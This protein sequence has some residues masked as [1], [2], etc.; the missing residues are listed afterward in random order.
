M[1]PDLTNQTFGAY[2]L[3]ALL[4]RG[5]MAAVYRGYQESIDRTVAV[6]VL[7]AMFMLDETFLSRFITEAK[8]LS[9]LTLDGI[10]PLYEF[11]EKNGTPY[12]VMPLMSGGSLENRLTNGPLPLTEVIRIVT[13]LAEALDYAHEQGIYHRDVKPSNILFDQRD[14]PILTDFGIAKTFESASSNLTNSMIIGTPDYMSPEQGRGLELDGRSDQYALGVVV[15]EALTGHVPFNAPNLLG[16]IYKHATEAPPSLR[17]H[18]TDLS[19]AVDVAVLKALAKNP[20]ERFPNVTGFARALANAAYLSRDFWL[21]DTKTKP[22]G[23]RPPQPSD[24]TV[25]IT[26]PGNEPKS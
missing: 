5:G 20:D 10:L 1:F 17:T 19:E 25:P 22:R 23:K 14:E 26:R 3:T 24:K 6:K 2:K 4:G 21:P 18:N 11:G 15:Y 9:K 8:V 16:I 13:P 7:P 12:I